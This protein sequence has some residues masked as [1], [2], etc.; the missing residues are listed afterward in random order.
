MHCILQDEIGGAVLADFFY[1]SST[2]INPFTSSISVTFDRN[3]IIFLEVQPWF[4]FIEKGKEVEFA[5]YAWS[6]TLVSDRTNRDIYV[7]VYVGKAYAVN[8]G[9]LAIKIPDELPS[10]E[11]RVG[12]YNNNTG[13]L[14]FTAWG[15]MCF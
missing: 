2:D 15:W 9:V 10:G 11:Y 5:L 8:N 6:C 13:E 3:N 12:F 14:Y 1:D 4:N 7:P